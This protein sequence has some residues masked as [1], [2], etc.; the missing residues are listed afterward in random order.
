MKGYAS[1][2]LTRIVRRPVKTWGLLRTFSRHMP[3]G[4]LLRL[5]SG[6]FRKKVA[7]AP[8]LPAPMI[9]AGITVP[10]RLAS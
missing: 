10:I 4:D 6:P 1:L 9:D 8:D 7:P 5:I 2:L 3:V